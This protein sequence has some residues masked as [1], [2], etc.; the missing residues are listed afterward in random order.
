MDSVH[1]T[2]ELSAVD[3]LV[4]YLFRFANWLDL[5][6]TMGNL[7]LGQVK[8]GIIVIGG[9]KGGGTRDARPPLGPEI[10][11]FLCSFREKIEK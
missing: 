6:S 4:R 5:M 7:E 9:S 10:L 1:S 2:N 11:S 8:L 3:I